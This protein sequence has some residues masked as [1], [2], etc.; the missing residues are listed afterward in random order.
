METKTY[1]V[2]LKE[3]VDYNQ[4]WADIENPTSGLPHIPDRAVVIVNDRLIFDRICE[5]A[6]TD[7][8]ADRVRNDPR[9]DSID[10]PVEDM[11]WITVGLGS[12]IQS[13]NFTKPTTS[14]NNFVNWG[15]P[16]HNNVLNSYLTNTNP[17]YIYDLDG[18]NVDVI[19]SDS[20]I[21]SDHP[22][23]TDKNGTSRVYN[24]GWDNI[25]NQVNASVKTG[26]NAVSYITGNNSIADGHGTHVAGTVAGKT[27]GWAKNARIL[28]LKS[29]G[30]IPGNVIDIF[31][32]IK[33][34]HQ[35]K[36]IN[37]ATGR[38]NPTVVNMSWGFG[39]RYSITTTQQLDGIKLSI[40][41]GVYRGSQWT[42]NNSIQPDSYYESKGLL[43][44]ASPFNISSFANGL[45]FRVASYDNALSELIDAGII[46]CRSAM[47]SSYKK[48]V[49]FGVDYNN[50]VTADISFLVSGAGYQT[51]YYH[52]GQSPSVPRVIEV[53]NIDSV[54]TNN[55]DQAATSSVKGPGV[56]IWAAGTNIMSSWPKNAQ[57]AT[58]SDYFKQTGQGWKQNRLTG[59]SMAS[60]QI[61]GMCALYLQKYPTATPDDV[62]NWLLTNATTGI[63]NTGANNDYTNPRS[64]LGGAPKVAYQN[65]KGSMHV[66]DS[67]GAWKQVKAVWIKD[68]DIWKQVNATYHN[69]NGTWTP[70]FT[71]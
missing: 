3:G 71:G 53:G 24:P 40:F 64:L 65:L 4:F 21:Q 33:Y 52:R 45:N 11:P 49:P 68:K 9:V 22:E 66:K 67:T 10:R 55:I 61:A 17:P 2:A 20:G 5:Y 34:W 43:I 19:I 69:I 37:P 13:D 50:S 46:I 51:I 30:S 38:K 18:T 7:D 14:N 57:D 31:S 36:P 59:T 47:N 70:T 23:F 42:T 35:N 8:E 12:T 41:G 63:L 25:A 60:P 26:W 48:D 39:L 6:L 54:I 44:G 28:S 58:G 29:A 1:I 62:K 16:R 15:M 27:Y 56:D 32:M